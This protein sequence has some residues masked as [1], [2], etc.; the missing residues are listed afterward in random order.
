[1]F[2]EIDCRSACNALTVSV[3]P[4]AIFHVAKDGLLRC[5]MRPFAGLFAMS[6]LNPNRSL[7]FSLMADLGLL[8]LDNHRHLGVVVS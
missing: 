1:M 5:K 6:W 2:L 3:K 7:D 4:K 8:V